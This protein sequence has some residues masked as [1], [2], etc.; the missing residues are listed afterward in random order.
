MKKTVY[1]ACVGFAVCAA[2]GAVVEDNFES[3][4]IG[5]SVAGLN[6][7]TVDNATANQN[8]LVAATNSPFSGGGKALY[9]N[10]N[11]TTAA[12]GNLM[13]KNALSENITE[14]V[15]SFDYNLDYAG[16]RNPTF[17]IQDETTGEVGVQ[18]IIR[19]NQ[20]MYK[21]GAGD[22]VTI[23]NSEL[24]YDTWYHIEVTVADVTGTADTFDLRIVKEDLGSG[25]TE[26]VN[27]TGLEFF[28]DVD[29]MTR[30]DIGTWAANGSS[31]TRFHLDNVQVVPEPATLGLI[32][33]VGL[34]LIVVRRALI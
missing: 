27:E 5:S 17:F 31:G 29:T 23:A 15:F 16:W 13:L 14:G 19:D 32:G 33:L 4:A 12:L 2:Q 26:I 20:Y 7:W 22:T 24:A 30:I 3:Y 8:A 21:N 28:N 18:L 34:G 6:G 10:D 25:P 11:D 1:M 9:Y